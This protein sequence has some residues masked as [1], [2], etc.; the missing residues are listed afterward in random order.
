MDTL[1]TNTSSSSLTLSIIIP[2]Y[3]LIETTKLCLFYINKNTTLPIE[4]IIVDD[5][6]E[7]ETKNIENTLGT[8]YSFKVLR[9]PENLGFAPS[10]NK[11]ILEATGDYICIFNNDLLVTFGWELPLISALI[12][13]KEYGMVSGST[14]S[15][16]TAH[17]TTEQFI[18]MEK[19]ESMNINISKLPF[20]LLKWGKDLP[21]MFKKET[22]EKIGLFDEQFVP[23]QYEDID[24]MIR[25]AKAKILFGKVNNSISYHLV[26]KT[27]QAAHPKWGSYAGKTRSLFLN[28]W[29]AYPP[30]LDKYYNES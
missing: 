1:D 9:N 5:G 13:N 17:I 25:M 8:E 11:G 29:G 30:D 22:F 26:S 12:G 6:S 28:K 21:W 10:C 7:D 19:T 3:N 4:V 2:C 24:I 27:Q 18:E 20:S 15:Y 16:G 14:I 23:A